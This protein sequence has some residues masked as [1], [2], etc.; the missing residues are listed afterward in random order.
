MWMGLYISDVLVIFIVS[1]LCANKRLF[2][3]EIIIFFASVCPMTIP[4]SLLQPK[5]PI[6]VCKLPVE[7]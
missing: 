3:V 5:K 6:G 4:E 7:I 1:I 2:W